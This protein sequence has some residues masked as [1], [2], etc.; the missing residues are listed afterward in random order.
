MHS[1][2]PFEG[3]G[4]A[5]SLVETFRVN[6]I[7]RPES[8]IL[9][10]PRYDWLCFLVT[11]LRDAY[12]F[13]TLVFPWIVLVIRLSLVPLCVTSLLYVYVVLVRIYVCVLS[14]VVVVVCFNFN[15]SHVSRISI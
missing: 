15:A 4:R 7:T 9:G 2:R 13:G 11:S 3:E 8:T 12:V 14:V 1:M 10:V 6:R 5:F